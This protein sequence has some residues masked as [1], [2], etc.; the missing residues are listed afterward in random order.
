MAVDNCQ[1]I[2][3]VLLADKAAGVL[4]EGANLVLEGLRIADQLGLIKHLVDRF[5]DLIAY[6]DTH[7]DVDST[8]LVRDA[9]IGAE[10]LEPFGASAAGGNDDMIGIDGAFVVFL[11]NIRAAADLVLDDHIGAFKAE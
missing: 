11:G 5:H 1:I 6:L 9:V 3:V 8:G 4:A 7:A 10:G 2:V